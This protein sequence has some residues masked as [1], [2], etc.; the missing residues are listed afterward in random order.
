MSRLFW[1]VV[2]KPTFARN[3]KHVLV[4]QCTTDDFTKSVDALVYYIDHYT[5]KMKIAY[6]TLWFERNMRSFVKGT[7]YDI[8]LPPG[9][10]RPSV[11]DMEDMWRILGLGAR[12]TEPNLLRPEPF[13]ES[14]YAVWQGGDFISPM[15]ECIPEVVGAMRACAAPSLSLRKN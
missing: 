1:H 15:S 5:D 13:S 3:G 2:V 6:P 8:Y 10:L 4:T 9:L 7:I 12:R 14:C 11:E